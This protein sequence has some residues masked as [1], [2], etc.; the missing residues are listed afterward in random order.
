M[1]THF[2]PSPQQMHIQNY[3]LYPI[4][5]TSQVLQAIYKP[6]QHLTPTRRLLVTMFDFNLIPMSNQQALLIH[7]ASNE[8]HCV[9]LR[10]HLKVII[11]QESIVTT[12]KKLAQPQ[13]VQLEIV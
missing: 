10:E 12:L 4:I 5:F 1:L 8:S 9:P 7:L 13:N 3:L 2:A 6:P 11:K